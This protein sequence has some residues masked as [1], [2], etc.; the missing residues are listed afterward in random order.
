[1]ATK[2]R[3]RCQDCGEMELAPEAIDLQ[4]CSHAPASYYRYS[5][6]SCGHTATRPVDGE[7]AQVLI[8]AGV[9]PKYWHLPAE[10][11]EPHPGPAITLDDVLDFHLLL[12]SEDWFDALKQQ[13]AA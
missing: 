4:W 13:S 7:T 1:M 3:M 2:F 6:P 10:A 8:G 12:E 11:M 5:C 9:R